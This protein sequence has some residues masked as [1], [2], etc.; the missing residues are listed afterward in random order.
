MTPSASSD[1]YPWI[2]W[3]CCRF[4][5]IERKPSTLWGYRSSGLRGDAADQPAASM[6]LVTTA[7]VRCSSSV[8]LNSTISV[9]S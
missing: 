4:G 2:T 3:D 8:G 6:F 5:Q 9:P 7:S 1:K